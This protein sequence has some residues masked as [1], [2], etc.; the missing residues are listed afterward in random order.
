M[1]NGR[2]AEPVITGA[3]TLPN[4]KRGSNEM[5]YEVYS[6]TYRVF[7]LIY[8]RPRFDIRGMVRAEWKR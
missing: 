8:P 2:T 5:A 3:I 6:N 4:T 1:L 7:A